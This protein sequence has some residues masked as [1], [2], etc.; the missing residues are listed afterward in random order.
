MYR[1]EQRHGEPEIGDGGVGD[2][3]QQPG[4]KG[5]IDLPCCGALELAAL[6]E[7]RGQD[8]GGGADGGKH[9]GQHDALRQRIDRGGHGD[10]AGEQHDAGVG[11]DGLAPQRLG[12]AAGLARGT[13]AEVFPHPGP[14]ATHD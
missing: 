13:G 11:S 14:E 12:A 6:A 8:T 5:G 10:E 1:P 9:E 7:R 4:E 2:G 3:Q